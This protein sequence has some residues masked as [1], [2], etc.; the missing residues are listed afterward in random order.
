VS[1][2]IVVSPY[3]TT[4]AAVAPRVLRSGVP[5][6]RPVIGPDAIAYGYR[7][8]A[9]D[10]QDH[11]DLISLADG[12]HSGIVLPTSGVPLLWHID[13]DPLWVSADEVVV[14]GGASVVQS[15]LFRFQRS[16]FAPSP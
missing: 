12:S 9:P 3:A 11:L 1:G 6:T 8:P 7:G 4:A 15:A 2:D 5:Y 10:Y 16:A 13:G 14:T